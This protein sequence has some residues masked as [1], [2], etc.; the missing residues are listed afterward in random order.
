MIILS[1]CVIYGYIVPIIDFL[2]FHEQGYLMLATVCQSGAWKHNIFLAS[3]LAS[4]FSATA[5]YRI[6]YISGLTSIVNGSGLNNFVA[7]EVSKFSILLTDA[8]QYPS[9]H[10]LERLQVQITLPSHLL[11]VYPQIHPM[12]SFNGI[13][14]LSHLLEFNLYQSYALT[15]TS[16][17]IDTFYFLYVVSPELE[18]SE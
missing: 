2:K 14:I 15:T 3:S 16:K 1:N 4:Q 7:R 17:F 6:G 5:W 10:D 18:N 13:R 9:P 8:F 12:D 11:C